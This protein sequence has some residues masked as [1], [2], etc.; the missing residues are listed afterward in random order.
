MLLLEEAGTV[1]W[2]VD[3][4]RRARAW[5]HPHR[6]FVRGRP[7]SARRPGQPPSPAQLCVTPLAR[8]HAVA[9]RRSASSADGSSAGAI[10]AGA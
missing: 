3:V 8:E 4:G 7:G 5:E 2:E 9:R 1:D 6:E 10:T